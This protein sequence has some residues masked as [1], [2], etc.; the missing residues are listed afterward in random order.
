LSGYSYEFDPHATNSTAATVYHAALAGGRRVLDLG[1]GSGT[2]ARALASSGNRRVT[3]VDVD[4]EALAEAKAAGVHDVVRVDLREAEWYERLPEREY[5]V[6]IMADVLEHLTDP[7]RV[8]RALLKERVLAADGLLV[9]SYPNVA[10]ESII[11][12]LLTGNFGYRQTGL[13]ANTHPRLFTR[14][15]MQALLESTGFIVAETRRTVRTAEQTPHAARLTELAPALRD[16]VAALGDD[17]STDQFI[18]SARPSTAAAAV[19][20]ARAELAAERR[21]LSAEREA[22]QQTLQQVAELQS[23]IRVVEDQLGDARERVEREWAEM[24]RAR[25]DL[26]RAEEQRAK[27]VRTLNQLKQQLNA[28]R[29]SRTYKIG[30]AVRYLL[31]PADG[32]RAASRRRHRKAVTEGEG[33]QPGNG[34]APLQQA[35]G[36]LP[37]TPRHLVGIA[38]DGP[39]TDLYEAALRARSFRTDQTKVAFLVSTVR[40]SAGRGDVFVAVGLGR[41]LAGLGYEVAYFPEEEWDALPADTD[42]TVALLPRFDPNRAPDGSLVVAW[43]RDE[44]DAWCRLPRLGLFDLVLASSHLSLD[45]VREV[46]DGPTGLLPLG[47]DTDLFTLPARRRKRIGV[48][49]T[50]NQWGRQWHLWE[51]LR[52]VDIDFPFAIVGVRQGVDP[53]FFRYSVGSASYLSLPDVFRRSLVVLDALD[54]TTRPYGCVNPRLLESLAAGAMPVTNSRLGL[55]ELGLTDVP[56]YSDGASLRRR[57]ATLLRNPDQTRRRARV[58]GEHVI[59][60]HSFEQRAKAFAVELARLR[61]AEP[62]RTA[63]KV[64]AF[65]PDYARNPFQSMLMADL[66]K[67]GVLPFPLS[68]PVANATPPSRA[69]RLD[70]YLLHVHWSHPILHAGKD[71]D[72]AAQRLERFKANI[73]DMKARGGKLLWT[74]HNVF[75]HE[76]RF[77]DLETDLARFLV[78]EAEAVHVLTPQTP[79]R[80]ADHYPLPAEKTVLIPHSSYVGRYSESIS[81]V[82]ARARLGFASHDHVFLAFGGLRPYKGLDVLLDAFAKAA[83]AD[84]R[85]RLVVAGKPQYSA[86]FDAVA[87]ACEADPRILTMFDSVPDDE[88][89]VYFRAADTVVLPY[90]SI[91][92]SGALHLAL[93]F[94]R[95]VVLP[96]LDSFRTF[97]GLPYATTFMQGDVGSLHDALLAAREVRGRSVEEAAREAAERNHPRLM[98]RGYADLIRRVMNVEVEAP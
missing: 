75:A 8:L 70:N 32:V 36:Y 77:P 3:C 14:T 38:A 96:D 6:V 83:D 63:R 15:S 91:L 49:T 74:V 89:Q 64:V 35:A 26:Q 54:H 21:A 19:A 84:P 27:E 37:N 88:V 80:T 11:V 78:R 42:V 17:A 60:R 5:D 47:V 76:A 65:F 79:A 12:E 95:P 22:H 68:D 50:V 57:L 53:M 85:L 98:A 66:P 2:V 39:M 40:L 24:T 67:L 48:V 43:I 73:R 4:G 33:G 87:A 72:E 62:R 25:T 41:K 97:G 94:G 56:V 59:A 34:T 51:S 9:V 1:S 28:L 44:T 81:R 71:H 90:R 86:A 46:Y 52:A 10:H 69:G 13:L 45:H 31:R 16:A 7:E 20:L 61:G 18:V 55:A 29:S 23:R 92:N 93:T 30:L 58:M 82:A